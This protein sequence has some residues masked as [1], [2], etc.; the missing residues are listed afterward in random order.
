MARSSSF[1]VS[2][3]RTA[4]R[5]AQAAHAFMNTAGIVSSSEPTKKCWT[6]Q[7]RRNGSKL[8]STKRPPS[9]RLKR[10]RRRPRGLPSA[11]AR[12]PRQPQPA[13]SPRQ[14]RLHPLQSPVRLQIVLVPVKGQSLSQMTSASPLLRPGSCWEM[15]T[16]PTSHHLPLPSGRGAAP[17]QMR[18]KPEQLALVPS[19]AS[20]S[21]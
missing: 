14:P 18:V 13:R 1:L 10:K 8:H 4:A 6:R 5:L 12:R 9:P 2:P 15:P 3:T 19:Y 11:S 7:I 21:S 17:L 16:G 20:S